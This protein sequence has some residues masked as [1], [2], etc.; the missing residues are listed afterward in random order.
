[1]DKL[2][3]RRILHV[4]SPVRW[5][6]TKWEHHGDSNWKMV[7][8]I[9]KWLPD[10]HHYI[11]VPTNNTIEKEIQQ[12]N[13]T[14]IPFPYPISVL[15]NRG[16][17][18]YKALRKYF[19]WRRHD[20]DFIFLNQ[21]ELCYNVMAGLLSDRVGTSVDTFLFFHWVDSPA[22]KPSETYIDGFWRQI[23][24]IDL[25]T[26]TFF[27]SKASLEYLKSNWSEK[28]SRVTGPV[29]DEN[30]QKKIVYMTTPGG[31]V[32]SNRKSTPV[33]LPDKKILLF[34]HR[35]NTTT[36]IKRLIDYTK[37]L[38]R[39]EYLV[40]VTDEGAKKP[41]AGA[42]APEWMRVQNLKSGAEYQYLIENAHAVLCFVDG[43][44]TWN[45]SIQDGVALKRPTVTYH[46]SVM[47]EIIG[48]DYPFYF[49]TK[50]EF[51]KQL[52]SITKGMIVERELP[53]HEENF[54]NNLIDSMIESIETYEAKRKQEPHSQEGHL[55]SQDGQRLYG[56]EWLWHIINDNSYKKN[57]L[58]NT[59]KDLHL[60]NSWEHLRKWI[61]M[62]GAVDDPNDSDA[63]FTIPED[64]VEEI[65][66]ILDDP[67]W[68]NKLF[69]S[70]TKRDPRFVKINKSKFF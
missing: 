3:G 41:R 49:K 69:A 50:D 61:L 31:F 1:M 66:K 36:G 47:D 52:K 4:L 32:G 59:H 67:K 62:I 42:P 17:F 38:D 15:A 48:D 23:E 35:W 68:I 53:P 18:D 5:N 6:A 56:R 11:L 43:Y 45:L 60:S 12:D 54:R 51:V 57:I 28:R 13:I 22:S 16:F 14:W 20:I 27:H 26:K 2:Y 58:Y 24:A 29:I 8:M 70:E 46:H 44:A 40:W 30:V 34:N 64:K 10:C 37:D 21:P 25:S 65:K 33:P 55:H 9:I 39:N 63:C 19:D 7:Q